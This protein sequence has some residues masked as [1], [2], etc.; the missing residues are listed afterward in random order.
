MKKIFSIILAGLIFTGLGFSQES[1][2]R[3]GGFFNLQPVLG[4]MNDYIS[5]S[6]GG[7]I[8]AE[9]DLPLKTSGIKIGI[10]VNVGFN[11][12]PSKVPELSSIFNI[13]TTSG[14]Y[15]RFPL[16]ENNFII[17]PALNYGVLMNCPIKNS[18]YKDSEL[19]S[20]Y[21]DNLIQFE[22]SFRYAP[23]QLKEGAFEFFLTPVYAFA[24]VKN[25]IIHYAGAKL[26][27]M[28]RIF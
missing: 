6:I 9:F 18:G 2:M 12:N 25:S 23:Q 28:Y 27:V 13:Q 15:V 22:V 17:Q 10:P 20:I 7:G 8:A 14:I 21:I 19:S 24:P 5:M 26:G 4:E 3:T 11:A 1:G 16:L